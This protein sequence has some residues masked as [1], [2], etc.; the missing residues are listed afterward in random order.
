MVCSAVPVIVLVNHMEYE[1]TIFI[2]FAEG[3]PVKV[4]E[5]YFSFYGV[6]WLERDEFAYKGFDETGPF[7]DVV[8]GLIGDEKDALLNHFLIVDFLNQSRVLD[9][10]FFA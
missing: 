1:F 4:F 9:L 7:C 10:L 8:D 2:G 3:D 5:G 6:L